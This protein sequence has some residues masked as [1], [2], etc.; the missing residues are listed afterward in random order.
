MMLTSA[1]TL[2]PQPQQ[3]TQQ[4][5]QQLQQQQQQQKVQQQLAGMQQQ[6]NMQQQISYQQQQLIQAKPPVLGNWRLS[7]SGNFYSFENFKL[8]RTGKWQIQLKSKYG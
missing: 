7:F 4:Q 1:G 8:V 2:V 6:L 3:M 5:Q